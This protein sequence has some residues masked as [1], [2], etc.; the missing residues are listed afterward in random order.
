ML[1]MKLFKNFHIYIIFEEKKL[2]F[3][4]NY[5]NMVLLFPVQYQNYYL[6][7]TQYQSMDL[8]RHCN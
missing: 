1:L 5:L 6:F 3:K 7:Q 4:L 2:E 8:Q